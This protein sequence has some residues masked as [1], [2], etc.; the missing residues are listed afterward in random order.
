M[1]SVQSISPAC[2]AESAVDDSEMNRNVTPE[3]FGAPAQYA[4]F[5][6][7]VIESPLFWLANAKGPVPTGCVAICPLSTLWRCTIATPLNP[8]RL[9]RRF[10]VGCFSVIRT[11]DWSGAVTPVTALNL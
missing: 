11:V 9:V 10:G 1:E 6:F 8:P 7:K 4:G 2:S 3:T 5:A